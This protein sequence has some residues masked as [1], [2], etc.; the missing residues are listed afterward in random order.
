M[1]PKHAHSLGARA[2]A[3]KQRLEALEK[4]YDD[5]IRCKNCDKEIEIP[6]D[7]KVSRIARRGRKFCSRSCAAAYNN[8]QRVTDQLDT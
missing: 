2:R 6:E 1:F 7:T 5:P 8:R 3:K 4:Y